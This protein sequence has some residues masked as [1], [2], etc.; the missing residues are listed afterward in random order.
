MQINLLETASHLPWTLIFKAGTAVMSARLSTHQTR[1]SPRLWF[2]A[3]YQHPECVIW[4]SNQER[5][6]HENLDRSHLLQHF[7]LQ[8]KRWHQPRKVL[9]PWEEKE[10]A[11]ISG[12]LLGKML[13]STKVPERRTHGEEKIWRRNGISLGIGKN[14]VFLHSN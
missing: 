1:L 3:I 13:S 14:R 4:N 8:S 12:T 2:T 9:W 11:I 10:W 6:L 7:E 5:R